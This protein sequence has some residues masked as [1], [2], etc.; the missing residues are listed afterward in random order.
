MKINPLH[1]RN[2]TLFSGIGEESLEQLCSCLSAKERKYEP[3]S[4][5]FRAGDSIDYVYYIL[6]GSIN[7]IDED[8][9]GNQSIVETMQKDTLFGEAYIF[10]SIDTYLVS[11]VAAEK[12]T[13]LEI[14]PEKLFET[15]SKGCMCHSLLVKN[16]LNIVSEKV[17]RLTEKVMHIMRRTTRAKLLSYLSVC[18][19]REKSTSIDIPYSRQQLA[20]YLCVDR[21]ALSHE[22]SRLQ[23]QGILRYHKNH[24][25]LV[26]KH[27]L[28]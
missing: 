22:L 9:W 6:S 7:I 13:I 25:E 19:Q 18:A 1:L 17:V 15:C 21:S 23:K 10:S 27:S 26:D 5:I 8:Y 3:G 11:V 24:F 28:Q 2:S 12:S 20:D 14:P 4:F 16:T